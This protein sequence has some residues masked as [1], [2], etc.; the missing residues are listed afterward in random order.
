MFCGRPGSIEVK[1]YVMFI[2]S[3][4]IYGTK[5]DEAF[6]RQHFQSLRINSQNGAFIFSV[7]M[8][9]KKNNIDN[10]TMSV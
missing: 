1:V 5:N 10:I 6:Q 8:I 7:L 9:T 3:A 2:Y 4:N